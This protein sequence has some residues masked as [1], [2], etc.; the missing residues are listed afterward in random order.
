MSRLN[1]VSDIEPAAGRS[2]RKIRILL[3]NPG[4]WHFPM[5]RP[6]LE[7]SGSIFAGITDANRSFAEDLG[8]ELDAPVFDDLETMLASAQADFAF[9]FGPHN[10]LPSIGHTLINWGMPFSLEK[11]GGLT[12]DQVAG[13]AQAAEHTDLFVSVPFHYRLSRLS[14]TMNHLLSA[15]VSAFRSL[16]FNLAA[17]TPLQHRRLSP[18]LMDPAVAGG[19]C[20]INLGHHP[21][22]Y[23]LNLVGGPL[24]RVSAVTSYA[25]LVLDVEDA[26]QLTLEFEN[27]ARCE[28]QLSYSTP[29]ESSGNLEFGLHLNHERF[30][31]QSMPTSLFVTDA[32]HERGISVPMNWDFRGYFADYASATL[33]RFISD[34]TPIASLRNLEATMRVIDAAYH[35]AKTGLPV[36][37]KRHGAKAQP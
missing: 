5:Y 2:A 12:A 19:G 29:L 15:P 11:P 32:T 24:R 36:D 22:D 4:H 21:I 20:L 30:I 16:K 6:G 23:A 8:R 1:D 14:Q 25:G 17:K 18:W 7:S 35:S 33:A 10:D 37:M 27:G 34:S 26:A 28:I 31:A 9:A 13:L 3:I